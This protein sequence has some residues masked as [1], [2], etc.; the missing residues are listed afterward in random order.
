MKAAGGP[1]KLLCDE[2]LSGLG[3]WLRAAGH[4][5]AS[6]DRGLPDVALLDF[7]LSEKRLLLTCDR[8]LATHHRGA[9]TVVTLASGGLE[10]T[11][12]ELGERIWI[13]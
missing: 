12:R 13:D 5:A 6:A 2:M 10:A 11:A 8:A 9:G 4:D 3:R 7:A 1:V